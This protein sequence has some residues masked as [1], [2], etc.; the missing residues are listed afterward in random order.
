MDMSL[1][2]AKGR[3]AT[4]VLEALL[5]RQSYRTAGVSF[6]HAAGI[7]SLHH[8]GVCIL[9]YSGDFT[10]DQVV[11]DLRLLAKA[12]RDSIL[13]MVLTSFRQMGLPDE[14]LISFNSDSD[15]INHR[16]N[17]ATLT[18]SSTM[19]YLHMEAVQT[20]LTGHIR[21]FFDAPQIRYA[22][23]S[24][25][26]FSRGQIDLLG[27]RGMLAGRKHD[28]Y[29]PAIADAHSAMMQAFEAL[30]SKQHLLARA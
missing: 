9:S 23:H 20:I 1:E 16:L 18:I 22:L 24:G 7:T 14:Y 29:A 19:N 2:H 10:R 30:N 6:T 8:R 11:Q 4:V 26:Q 15:R 12:H 5:C 25:Q 28:D 17:C 13:E 27:N 3:A 21:V